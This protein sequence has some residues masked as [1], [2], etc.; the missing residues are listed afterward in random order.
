MYKCFETEKVLYL[1]LELLTG[2]ELFDTSAPIPQLPAGRSSSLSPLRPALAAPPTSMP[3]AI[4][5]R[6]RWHP[7]ASRLWHDV[8]CRLWPCSLACHLFVRAVIAK[9]HYS[10]KDAREV[11]K[12]LLKAIQ[13]LHTND[14]A[15]R[16]LKPEN[17]LLKDA[18]DSAAIKVT[19]FGLS[20]IFADDAAGE[21]VMKTACGTPGYVA[22]E[23]LM[24]D[25]YS[26]QVDLWSIG[27][28]VY[29]L[30]CG[31]PPFYGDND[32]QMFKKIKAGQYKFL[33][34]Y[35]DPISNDAKDFVKNLLIVD[36]KKRMTAAEALNHRWLGRTSSVSTKNLFAGIEKAP[37][38]DVSDGAAGGAASEEQSVEPDGLRGQMI[39]YNLDRKGAAPEKL[40]KAFGLPEGS[41]RFGKYTCSLGNALGNLYITSFHLCF[42]GAFGKKVAVALSDIHTIAKVKRFKLSP[43][44]GHSLHV[45]T[46]KATLELNG[47]SEREAC[48]KV[49]GGSR[50]GDEMHGGPAPRRVGGLVWV[51]RSARSVAATAGLESS[52]E[53]GHG[54]RRHTW[55]RAR[56]LVSAILS[57]AHRS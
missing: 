2:G 27:V 1:V 45:A 28:I 8:F 14:V 5:A 57:R 44:S 54:G 42:Y 26:S 39:Q 11:T 30:L 6:G 17:I 13:Y 43:G 38:T 41:K 48:L 20:K 15:H 56:S 49:R 4:W 12:T 22:P 50:G 19:D 55:P 21:I 37:P 3:T 7:P 29:I 16:D 33:A 46:P 53:I 24:H 35:W 9:G 40:V 10:E 18:T 36:P 47:I 52:A 23:V 32:Q 31:F 25:A 34:P 51:Q